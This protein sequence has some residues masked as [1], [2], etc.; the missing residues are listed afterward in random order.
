MAEEP[1]AIRADIA[2]T[3]ARLGDTVEALAYKAD[4]KARARE[5]IAE[6]REMM[7]TAT[8]S[9]VASVRETDVLAPT[10]REGGPMPDTTSSTTSSTAQDWGDESGLLRRNPLAVAFGALAIGFLAGM[11]VPTTP[12]ENERLG[13]VADQVKQSAREAAQEAVGRGKAI[14]TE[15]AQTATSAV[16]DSVQGGT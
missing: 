8:D 11:L 12:A 13:P 3:R 5:K 6:L 16:K 2:A 14:A 1:D 15:A 7:T 10:T 4:V 9:F